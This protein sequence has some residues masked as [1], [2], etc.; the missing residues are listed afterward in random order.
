MQLAKVAFG[1]EKALDYVTVPDATGDG[2][3]EHAV[4]V[5]GSLFA[6][7]KNPVTGNLVSKPAFNP[8]FTPVTMLSPGDVDGDA[9]Q[10][11]AVVGR[12]DAT[13]RVQVES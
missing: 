8:A 12:D 3:P 13:G 4:L 1:P 9:G 2:I 6:R 5:E 11:L 10:D 7:V